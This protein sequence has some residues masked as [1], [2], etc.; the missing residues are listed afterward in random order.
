MEVPAG[1]EY[2]LGDWG[3]IAARALEWKNPDSIVEE[4]VEK[5]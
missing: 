2:Y 3:E 1:T 5:E 4:T